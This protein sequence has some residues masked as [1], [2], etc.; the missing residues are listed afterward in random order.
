MIK[1]EAERAYR[2]A[3]EDAIAGIITEET[4]FAMTQR[5]P[6]ADG[7]HIYG[8]LSEEWNEAKYHIETLELLVSEFQANCL[9]GDMPSEINA[10]DHLEAII[11]HCKKAILEI[12]QVA[13]V[14]A[15]GGLTLEHWIYE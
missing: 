6:F 8:A 14:S 1:N 2:N 15:K 4:G 3:M 5:K 13:A 9:S 10:N 12:T 7:C 11:F